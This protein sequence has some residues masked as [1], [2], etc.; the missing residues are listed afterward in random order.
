M[1]SVFKTLLSM[2]LSSCVV[3]IAVIILRTVLSGA[4]K[5]WSYLLWPVVG[6][7][8]CCPVSLR[9]AVSIFS[10]V[11][12]EV[13]LFHP[14]AVSQSSA[15]LPSAVERTL[16]APL[17]PDEILTYDAFPA[18]D[19]FTVCGWIW[20]A[21]A[22]GL[23]L[24]GCL[25]YYLLRRTLLDAVLVEKAVYETDK[26]SVPFIFGLLNPRIYLPLDLDGDR[27][28]YVLAHEHFHLRRGDHWAK[29]FAFVLLS[30]H[31]FNPLCWLSFY[32]LNRDMEISCDE[33][34]LSKDAVSGVEYS[35][36]LLSF[37]VSRRFSVS[38]PL[39]FGES[40]VSRR[41]KNA[42]RWK[43]PKSWVTILA[44][45]L[46][47]G[48]LAACATNP[49][50]RSGSS[51]GDPKVFRDAVL[52]SFDNSETIMM[53]FS[54]GT[55]KPWGDNDFLK[56]LASVDWQ[57]VA[58][59]GLFTSGMDCIK[60]ETNSWTLETYSGTD[61]VRFVPASGAGGGWLWWE[62]PEEYREEGSLYHSLNWIRKDESG[63]VQDWR[64]MD[65]DVD[66]G[67]SGRFSRY[68]LECAADAIMAKF[69]QFGNGFT[70]QRLAYD[71]DGSAE[72]LDWLNQHTHI[73]G[74]GSF[75]EAVCFLSDFHTPSL[76]QM[77]EQVMNPDSD[78]PGWSWWL[79]RT[80][81]GDWIVVDMGY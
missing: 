68:D 46:S 15:V 74:A 30:I 61:Y 63:S 57:G 33:H 40:D 29:F 72:E 60:L 69:A 36:S 81:D 20:L 42:L 3:M 8:L 5:K 56:S 13:R 1:A 34:V 32:L 12:A 51:A 19:W 6:F 25:R 50:H 64:N 48:T 67:S 38:G 78:Y 2:S 23:L 52:A 77:K 54:D 22:A 79:A 45:V 49:A 73:P 28:S 70:M 18:V 75:T 37:A 65:F 21:G 4:P 66:F 62:I 11:P 44:L 9:S 7:R 26:V 10:V 71:H 76:D 41:V 58:P 24:W 80:D 17:H 55:S 35:A 31:W 43:R 16:S 39:A 27:R 53:T 14:V 59:D 47:V